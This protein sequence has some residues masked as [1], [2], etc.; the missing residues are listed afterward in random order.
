MF[1]IVLG[2]QGSAPRT[3]P[4][5]LLERINIVFICLASCDWT[6]LNDSHSTQQQLVSWQTGKLLINVE[7]SA[8]SRDER[9]FGFIF[10]KIPVHKAFEWRKKR[11]KEL[12]PDSPYFQFV[13]APPKNVCT[14]RHCFTVNQI[15]A[16]RFW[17]ILFLLCR[18]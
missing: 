10:T 6:V 7:A 5:L 15:K 14:S 4:L 16:A 2:A 12:G 18:C 8:I 11:I 9:K 17:G 3:L 13:C 1:Q